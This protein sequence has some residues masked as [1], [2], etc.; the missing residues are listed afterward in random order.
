[1]KI[2]EKI[3]VIQTKRKLM[4][5]PGISLLAHAAA[6]CGS[7]SVAQVCRLWG[8]AETHFRIKNQCRLTPEDIIDLLRC[9]DPLA[10]ADQYRRIAGF[11]EMLPTHALL[12]EMNAD[13]RFPLASL[14][15]SID[16]F[17]GNLTKILCVL[18]IEVPGL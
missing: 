4:H 3:S 17:T 7:P 5:Q 1:M 16:M 15:K 10:I 14:K 13:M 12:N 6:L 18:P 2:S 9:A 8:L 11:S